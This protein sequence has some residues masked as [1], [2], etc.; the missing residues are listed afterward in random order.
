MAN[1]QIDKQSLERHDLVDDVGLVNHL[2]VFAKLKLWFCGKVN[3]I[4]INKEEE[5]T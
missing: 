4:Y 3:Q 5:D 1:K 2:R